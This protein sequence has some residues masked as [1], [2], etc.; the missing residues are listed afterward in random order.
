MK[1]LRINLK[2]LSYNKRYKERRKFVFKLFV[3]IEKELLH[4]LSKG[5]ISSKRR[6]YT[7]NKLR[8]Q[9]A[10]TF[11]KSG[12][13]LTRSSITSGFSLLREKT[14]CYPAP[15]N[16]VKSYFLRNPEFIVISRETFHSEKLSF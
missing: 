10:R 6:S 4:K 2:Y 16:S 7:E 1:I 14:S 8:L 3:E 11:H 9:I 5:E 12:K 13:R 15:Q